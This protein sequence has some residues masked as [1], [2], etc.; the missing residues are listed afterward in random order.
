MAKTVALESQ[1]AEMIE[2]AMFNTWVSLLA[3]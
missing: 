1:C 3:V 2:P